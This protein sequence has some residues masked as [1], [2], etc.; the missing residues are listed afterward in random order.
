[1]D[2][3]KS[4][5]EEEVHTLYD[6][7]PS[8]HIRLLKILPDGPNGEVCCQ[9]VPRSLD[10]QP[11][12]TALS[13]AWGSP[14][15]HRKI[16]LNGETHTVYENLWR[17]LSQARNLGSRFG[18]WLWIDALCINQSD[19]KDK[20]QQIVLM[21]DIYQSAEVVMIWLGPNHGDSDRAMRVLKKP[22]SY[23][24][25]KNNILGVW[26]KPAGIAIRGICSRRYWGR[27]WIFQ[28]IMLGQNVEVMCGAMIIPLDSLKKFLLLVHE[29]QPSSRVAAKT[30][31]QLIRHSP[32]WEIIKQMKD[33]HDRTLW[34]LMMGTSSL[35]CVQK[36]DYVYALLGIATK[37]K[38]DIVPDY[39]ASI[40][41]L[42][43][44]VLKNQ[45]KLQAPK[46]LE[47]VADQCRKL[48]RIL[49]I[50]DGSMYVLEGHEEFT[51]TFIDAEMHE[52]TFLLGGTRISFW[53]SVYYGHRV[54][55]SLLY[56]IGVI[57]F[58]TL[59]L[60]AKRGNAV[61]LKLLLDVHGRDV[62]HKDDFGYAPLHY[63][64]ENGHGHVVEMLLKLP[65]IDVNLRHGATGMSSFG[66]AILKGNEKI[67]AQILATSKFRL[68]EGDCESLLPIAASHTNA[69]ALVKLLLDTGKMNIN[70]TSQTGETALHVAVKNNDLA[71]VE[72]LLGT[73]TSQI[74][75]SLPNDE[76]ET[77]LYLATENRNLA[78]TKLLLDHGVDVNLKHG[79]V[80]AVRET[81][82]L[83]RKRDRRLVLARDKIKASV[84]ALALQDKTGGKA[85]FL[86]DAGLNIDALDLD[87]DIAAWFYSLISPSTDGQGLSP[88]TSMLDMLPEEIPWWME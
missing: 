63:A 41:V 48:E 31:Y 73:G 68:R 11:S 80:E 22:M 15:N 58:E 43:N 59:G 1:M 17:F 74:H 3:A 77:P 35:A 16:I 61:L 44:T 13:Y 2:N 12:Y 36:L 82:R 70:S 85:R 65:D 24:Q 7:L 28:E 67:A 62:D 84:L 88:R 42:L 20:E 21:P 19:N 57:P 81:A 47:E 23:W 33:Q 9:L 14:S 53:W 32:A 56:S 66:I 30:E 83:G 50:D 25:A 38:D 49:G 34:G 54:V 64:T 86:F 6:Y 71:T 10:T 37:G 29:Q 5:V 78:I 55:Q 45:H 60:V 79:E 4:S 75:V 27:L 52:F 87:G 76:G 39:K 72:L 69:A 46:T 8:R 18:G 40:P 26:G 51:Q